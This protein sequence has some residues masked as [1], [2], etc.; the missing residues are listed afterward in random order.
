M[1]RIKTQMEIGHSE[2][3]FRHVRREEIA[4]CR[5][6]T[7]IT[8]LTYTDPKII[9]RY[10]EICEDCDEFLTVK[11]ILVDCLLYHRERRPLKEYLAAQQKRFVLFNL[12]QDDPELIDLLMVYLRNTGL[13][14]RL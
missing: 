14:Y 7:N 9:N 6:R 4:L 8:R 12:L 13:L 3:S 10:P 5:L 11:H 2:T 1:D